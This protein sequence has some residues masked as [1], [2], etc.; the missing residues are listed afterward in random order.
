MKLTAL[1][2]GY[3]PDWAMGGETSTHRTLRVIPGSTVYAQ[4]ASEPYELDNVTVRPLQD[5]VE[6]MDVYDLLQ[7]NLDVMFAHSAL[8]EVAVRGARKLRK[9]SILSVHAPRRFAPDL[10]RAARGATVRLYNTD[11]AKKDW[12]DPSGWVLH[13]P[14]VQLDV[15]AGPRDAYTLA[16]SL[17]NKGVKQTLGLAALLPDKRFII[18]RS[19]AEATHGYR[20]F[21]KKA[22]ALP[23]VEVWDRLEPHEMGKLWSQTRIVLVPSNYE[24]Y[25]LVA[26]EAAW[27]GIPSVHVNTPHVL[28][29]IGNAARLLTGTTTEDVG[30]A[31]M[32]I[33]ADYQ[34]WANRAEDRAIILADREKLELERFAEG[35]SQLTPDSVKRI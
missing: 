15:V 29:G 27:W 3:P 5:P 30:M 31:I 1:I 23:N 19:P 13:P 33:E 16:S 18:V 4:S 32:D 9:P 24:T 7:G 14:A 35:V 25:G 26:V 20:G 34:M 10:V 12:R 17:A 28:E 21:E 8:S 2:H 6:V 22:A 11:A